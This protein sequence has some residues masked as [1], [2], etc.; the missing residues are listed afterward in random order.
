MTYFKFSIKDVKQFKPNIMK[1]L[2]YLSLVIAVAIVMTSCCAKKPMIK[3][4]SNVTIPLDQV[5]PEIQKQYVDAVN[6]LQADGVGIDV[7]A[8]DLGLKI[9]KKNI[10]SGDVQVLIFKPADKYTLTHE[11]SVIF[12]LTQGGTKAADQYKTDLGDLKTL[13]VS[14]AKQFANSSTIIGKLTKKELELDIAFTIENDVS[15][16]LT[17]KVLGVGADLGYE[18]DN[19]VEHDLTMKFTVTKL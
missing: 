9:T 16:G 13:I 17:F 15:G 12:H 6:E 18:Y 11:T 8:I 3:S 10:A 5:L 2:K 19:A 1:Q 4:T 7:S 14:S